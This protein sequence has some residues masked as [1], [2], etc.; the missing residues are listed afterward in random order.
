MTNHPNRSQAA[1]KQAEAL[2][3]FI[4]EGEYHGT[5]DNRIGRWYVGHE[6]EGGFRPFGAGHGTR[7]EAWAAAME[8]ARE[9][10]RS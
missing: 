8:H 1:R 6:S 2:G 5:T 4:R 10:G 3:Y 7:T 9:T